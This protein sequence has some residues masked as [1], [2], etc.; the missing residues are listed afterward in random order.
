M[1]MKK[2]IGAFATIFAALLCALPQ[3]AQ[4][5]GKIRSVDVYDP[6]GN[7][8]FPNPNAPL[9]VG[10]TIYVR[11]RLANLM[12]AETTAATT[13]GTSF[14][15]PWYFAYTGT[16]TGNETLDELTRIASQKPRLGL[17][18]SGRVRE[19]ECV[20]FPGVL[21]DWLANSLDGEMHYTELTF[22]Y[23]I[24]AGDFALPVQ[25]ANASGTGPAS[26]GMEPYYLK[27]EGQPIH[28]ALQSTNTTGMVTSDFSFGPPYLYEDPDFPGDLSK[29]ETVAGMNVEIRDLDLRGAGVYVQ[30]ID[31]DKTYADQ[32]ADIWRTIAKGSTTA[33]PGVPTVSIEGGAA[34][35]MTLYVWAESNTVA[36]VT[37]G[38]QVVELTDY[39]FGGGVTRKVG[40]L[41][42][43]A[44]DTSV[45]LYVKATGNVGDTTKLF[46]S[47]TPTNI[48]NQS[49]NLITN[50]I[51]RTIEVG[52][53]L[54]PSIS[55]TVDG[56]ASKEVIA[57]TNHTLALVAVNVQLSDAF[58]SDI[59]IPIKVSLKN[60]SLGL[61]PTNYVGLSTRDANNNTD[62]TT[63][64][65]V[66]RNQNTATA[67]LWMYANRGSIDTKSG[68]IFSVDTNSTTW[69]SSPAKDFFSEF[70]DAIVYI[71]P[72]NPELLTDMT[73]TYDAVSG[74]PKTFEIDVL[75]AFGERE[76]PYTIKWAYDYPPSSDADYTLIV[77]NA[78]RSG[79]FES[80]IRFEVPISM[81]RRPGIYT[82]YFHVVNQDGGRTSGD[83]MVVWNIKNPLSS[84]LVCTPIEDMFEENVSSEQNAVKISFADGFSMPEKY[85][86]TEGYLFLIP[87]SA[88]ATNLVYSQS[89]DRL[90]SGKTDV[91]CDWQKGMKIENGKEEVIV[92]M[93]FLD[94]SDETFPLRYQVVIRT[95]ERL[96]QGQLVTEWGTAHAFDL[97][98]INVEPT[99]KNVSVGGRNA[100]E[101]ESVGSFSSEVEK[102]F[103]AKANEPSNVD[104]LWDKANG[105]ADHDKSF[106]TRWEFYRDNESNPMFTTNVFGP[107]T[108]PF[109]YKFETAGEYT[110][111]VSMRDKD[112]VD[113]FDEIYWGEEFTFS[114]TVVEK[115]SIVIEPKYGTVYF[116]EYSP[117]D[118]SAINV[119]LTTPPTG[120]V[121]VELTID[122][123]GPYTASSDYPVPNLSKTTLEF[124]AGETTKSFQLRDLDGTQLTQDYGFLI[125]AAVTNETKNAD[126]VEWKKVYLPSELNI[127]LK[128]KEALF[129]AARVAQLSVTT[130]RSVTIYQKVPPL[131]IAFNDPSLIDMRSGKT[132]VQWTSS[133]GYSDT[134]FV[135]NQT[136]TCTITYSDKI[137]FSK[138]G[139]QWVEL[140]VRDKDS[141]DWTDS[142]TWYFEIQPTRQLYVT[143]GYPGSPA[144]DV[145]KGRLINGTGYG[146]VWVQGDNGDPKPFSITRFRHLY[147]CD[148]TT[149]SVGA[150]G[151]KA[152]DVDNGSL[153]PTSDWPINQSGY[154][155]TAAPYYENAQRA[156]DGKDSFMYMWFQSSKGEKGFELSRMVLDV[157][158]P[159]TGLPGNFTADLPTELL[160][161]DPATANFADTYVDAIFSREFL[162]SDNIGD[163]NQDRIPDIY[164]V[165]K[166]WRGNSLYETVGGSYT[167]G[168][169]EGDLYDFYNYN[170][171]ADYL[172]SNSFEG[173]IPSTANGWSTLGVPFDAEMEVRGFHEGLNHRTDSDGLNLFVRGKWVSDPHFSEAETNAVAFWNKVEW[174]GAVT[175]WAD[176]KAAVPTDDPDYATKLA[177]WQIAFTN[178]LYKNDSWIPEKRTNPTLWDTDNDSLPDGYE[179]YFWYR[180]AVGEMQDDKWVQLTGEKFT[181]NN[182]AKGTRLSAEDIMKAFDPTVKSA[183]DIAKR[184][185][186]NDGL[187][188]LEEFA[189]GTNPVHWDSDGDG[190]SDLWEVMRGM[191]PL[192]KPTEPEKNVDGDFMARALTPS[193]YAIVT[194]NNGKV[195]ALEQNGT[196]L[197][198]FERDSFDADDGTTKGGTNV[199]SSVVFGVEDVSNVTALAVFHYGNDSS[200]C[201]PKKRGNPNEQ[202]K[203]LDPDE[204]SLADTEVVS[205]KINQQLMLIHDQVYNQ[206]EFHPFTGWFVNAN[207]DVSH[208]WGPAVNTIPYNCTDEYLVMK[209]RYETGIAAAGTHINQINNRERTLSDIFLVLTTNPNKPFT[210]A[211]YTVT[212]A[213]TDGGGGDQVASVASIPTY[214]S[215]NHGADT[216]EDGI[217]D[218]WELYVG[219]N[220]N[221]ADDAVGDGDRDGLSLRNEY[222][223]S[224]SCN[225][226]QNAANAAGTATIYQYHPGNAKGWFNKFTPTDP[227]ASDSDKDGLNGRRLQ[228][229]SR[230]RPQPVRRRYRLR[231]PARRLGTPV[232]GRDGSRRHRLRGHPPGHRPDHQA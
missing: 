85:R 115:P 2:K 42:I 66:R 160:G 17:W 145:A 190:M 75:D 137:S 95:H 103:S 186:D 223:G 221:D 170:E 33:N 61:H 83:T 157:Y 127:Y 194:L 94:G 180:A 198:T 74:L 101:G 125:T 139:F 28:W 191:N 30:A 5:Y 215:A 49:N 14:S 19:A 21:T 159:L 148:G 25:L 26:G 15:N 207:G 99:I 168:M 184:D 100:S 72:S 144:A 131:S 217:P 31:F 96:D 146:R 153:L 169:V 7:R 204:V 84:G 108:E 81:T 208:R 9:T 152:N 114:F 109:K 175:T 218:G 12:W 187:T 106:A 226:Y 197:K 60:N 183:Q 163:I 32:T 118:M 227:K 199:L 196:N 67:S 3:S 116:S 211:A 111:K 229:H 55:V 166:V 34:T 63:T 80:T 192:K 119:T 91:S 77:T 113:W 156:T 222:A 52:D 97:N 134:Y 212:W 147:T 20:N 122:R 149:A 44:G 71:K 165:T 171:D 209:Y 231:P 195:Y 87:L 138:S 205:I 24:Q 29:W 182:I 202:V 40:S 216:D 123:D 143:P 46:L 129:D 47:A 232:R 65:K 37:S 206:H 173:G 4:A 57:P 68:L 54:P 92:K 112:M 142:V 98:I 174:N 78:T 82:N 140:K 16:L 224:D 70:N 53:P 48:Y 150:F 23:T 176:F 201:V 179:Y 105:Y 178:A 69:T 193:S 132:V 90:R 136:A 38:G 130:N 117:D 214:T 62:W 189:M 86:Q 225:A 6:D 133:Q 41:R 141:D 36:E 110:V 155:T 120:R 181:L 79:D 185:T 162:V 135:S 8:T 45:P 39:D 230:W 13:A 128:N 58:T 158:N 102:E 73:K 1:N 213:G 35:P 104:Y 200:A 228:V 18:I 203:P 88:E 172:P 107:P 11:F 210:E 121:L 76:G 51:T 219:A 43:N 10:D 64:L 126:G 188:D 56:A 177:E 50:F 89:F 59:D 151:Y 220:P 93:A 124:K 154:A 27:Y 161:D 164:A 22:K 167:D